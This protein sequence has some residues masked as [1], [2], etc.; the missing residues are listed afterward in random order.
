MR[1]I[2]WLTI[3]LAL[4]AIP[5]H[6]GVRAEG[7]SLA[8]LVG[9][10]QNMDPDSGGIVKV[11]ISDG[12][13]IQIQAFSACLPDPCDWGVVN[14]TAYGRNVSATRAIT[15]YAVYDTD[16]SI[17]VMTGSRTGEYLRIELFTK[18]TDDS[19]RSDDI[20]TSV[21]IRG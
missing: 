20:S 7:V 8:Q 9:T 5:S 12:D 13:G 17:S 19:G 18:F 14:G 1:R 21:F 4:I 10:W 16:H 6:P 2:I 3:L 11:I 15:F